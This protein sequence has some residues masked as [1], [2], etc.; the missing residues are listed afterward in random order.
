MLSSCVFSHRRCHGGMSFR[1]LK[2]RSYIDLASASV[3]CHPER[4]FFIGILSLRASPKA[5]VHEIIELVLPLAFLLEIDLYLILVRALTV[6][7]VEDAVA[8]L[9]IL[10][11]WLFWADYIW[12]LNRKDLAREECLSRLLSHLRMLPGRIDSF[13]L[14]LVHSL[15]NFKVILCLVDFTKDWLELCWLEWMLGLIK[16]WNDA[17]VTLFHYRCFVQGYCFSL[18]WQVQTLLT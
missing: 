18:R 2:H 16:V 1:I 17:F 6:A 10:D 9:S 7:H 5:I 8:A 11:R 12:V 14:T 4:P 13:S 15:V 3:G